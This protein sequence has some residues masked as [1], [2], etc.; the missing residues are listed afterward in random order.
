[1]VLEALAMGLPV[2]STRFNGACEIMTS[3]EHG[4]VLDDPQDIGALSSAM[5][6]MLDAPTRQRMRSACLALRPALSYERHLDVLTQIYQRAS[7]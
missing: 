3:G 2:L 4:F 7:N 1:V 5:R 6:A